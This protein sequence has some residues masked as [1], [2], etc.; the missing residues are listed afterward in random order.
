MF[1]RILCCISGLLRSHPIIYPPPLIHTSREHPFQ[2]VSSSSFVV[3]FR[4]SIHLYLSL[5]VQHPV[6]VVFIYTRH[7]HSGT[8]YSICNVVSSLGIFLGCLYFAPQ[9]CHDFIDIICWS[10]VS[11]HTVYHRAV[12]PCIAY[13][14]LTA[15]SYTLLYILSGPFGLTRLTSTDLQDEVCIVKIRTR[16][17]SSIHLCDRA[18]S[19]N[20]ATLLAE[21]LSFS[22]SACLGRQITVTRSSQ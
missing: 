21:C 2:S 22:C 13:L 14:S 10:P 20:T 8:S 9:Y 19:R 6:E 12:A 3:A 4:F 17:L 16:H 7:G 11:L 18:F 5:T 15:V 1:I